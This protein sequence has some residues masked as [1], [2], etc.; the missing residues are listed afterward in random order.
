MVA[1]FDQVGVTVCILTVR[2]RTVH[3]NLYVHG[4]VLGMDRPEFITKISIVHAIGVLQDWA[5]QHPSG[6]H[7]IIHDSLRGIVF[8]SLDRLN[9]FCTFI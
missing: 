1:I 9:S 4:R 8:S 5:M 6:L 3:R 2:D 7:N